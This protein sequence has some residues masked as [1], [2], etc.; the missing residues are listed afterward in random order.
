MI[1]LYLKVSGFGS[2]G[3]I[4]GVGKEILMNNKSYMKD[5]NKIGVLKR[6]NMGRK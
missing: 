4:P 1:D 5:M 6:G 2:S 3:P